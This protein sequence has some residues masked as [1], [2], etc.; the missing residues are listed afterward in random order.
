V[1]AN[2]ALKEIIK[3]KARE[4]FAVVG[5]PCHI[6]GIRKAQK[7]NKKLRN[8]ISLCF[9]IVCAHT[10]NFHFTNFTIESARVD[11]D[12]DV[13]KLDYRGNGWPGLMSVKMTD[14][15]QIYIPYQKY[16]FAHNA[17]MFCPW[18]CLSCIDGIGTMADIAFADD[19]PREQYPSDDPGRSFIVSRS[20]NGE[21]IL[22][23]ASKARAVHLDE[24]TNDPSKNQ[25][26]RAMIIFRPRKAAVARIMGKVV[27]RRA[28]R[29]DIALPTPR[30]SDYGAFVFLRIAA[31]QSRR[32]LWRLVIPSV[33]V[34][35]ALLRKAKTQRMRWAKH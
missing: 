10:D 31:L 7:F 15:C 32:C 16:M 35:H 1:P 5:L 30:L 20:A 25:Q 29:Y 34:E 24:A 14:G 19:W 17:E 23:A 18:R 9:S 28:P 4:R 8:A 27:G 26:V 12:R 2:I 3:A 6:H 13:L 21:A 22:G 33:S 11:S